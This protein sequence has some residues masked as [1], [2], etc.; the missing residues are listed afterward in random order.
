MAKILGILEKLNPWWEGK[1]FETG[2]ER[3]KYLQKIK[4]YIKTKEIAILT[5]IRRSGKTTL[6]FQ[7]IKDLIENNKIDPKRIFFVNFDEADIANLENPIEKVLN[8]YNQE[9]YSEDNSYFLFDEIQNVKDWE[10]WAK[11]I[12]DRKK[13]QLIISGSSSKLLDNKLATLISGRYLKINVFPLDFREYLDFNN[14]EDLSSKLKLISNKNKIMNMLKS[15]LAEG[16]FPQVALQPN[17]NLKREHLKTY[18][19]SIV[20]KDILSMHEIRHTKVMKELI[21]YLFSNFTNPY[22]YKQLSELLKVDFSTIKEYLDYIEESRMLFELCIFSYSLKTQSKNNKKVYCADNGLRNAI[23]FQ[24]S[25]DE[26]KLAENL[27]F[28]ELKR[29]E[30]EFFYWKNKGEVDF[31]IKNKDQSLIAMNVTY[32]NDI[33]E[34]EINSLIEFKKEFKKTKELVILTK[35]TEKKEKRIRF[36]PLWK[37]LLTDKP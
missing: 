8:T 23:S 24:F 28:I 31:I 26:G 29:R 7:T 36:I 37:W 18:Y 1:D 21:Y 13:N 30:K 5:G 35:D 20:Y 17:K 9:V 14:I 25:K 22:S 32:T 2:L 19:E 10:K 27:V 33:E 16:G 6:L 12:Y 4:S 34:R 11:T 15:Y 3:K